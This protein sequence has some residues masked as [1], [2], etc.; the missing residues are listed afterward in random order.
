MKK[1]AMETAVG[2]FVAIGLLCVGY[3]T[4]K[5]GNI[6]ILEGDQY[7][8]LAKFSSVS[9][10]RAGS[11]VQMYGIEVGRV[12]KLG[13]DAEAQ[14]AQVEMLIRKDIRIYEDALA[15]IKTEG[16][17]GDKYVSIDPGG[18]GEPLKP[19]GSIIQTQAAVDVGDL[20][21]KYAFGDVKKEEP[22]KK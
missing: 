12:D 5:L 11:T 6:G 1:Y 15:A 14:Q 3:L 16:L 13:M 21:S 22:E 19:G 10:L 8:V 18:I 9:G 2:I 4:V 20:I 7:R 17:I